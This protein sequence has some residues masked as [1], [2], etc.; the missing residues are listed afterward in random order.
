MSTWRDVSR[1]ALAYAGVVESLTA[2]GWRAWKLRDKLLAWERPLLRS[3]LQTLGGA[4]PAGAILAV[5]TADLAMKEALLAHDSGVFFTTPHFDGYPAVLIDLPRVP[6]KLLRE[7]IEEA[8]I[9]RAP[10]RVAEAFV[11]KRCV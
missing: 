7:V 10:K 9:A 5:R 8:W 3:D 6:A 1:I 11:A 4:G 2:R